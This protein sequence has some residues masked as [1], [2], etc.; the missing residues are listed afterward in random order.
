[1]NKF[2]RLEMGI[3][4]FL[5]LYLMFTSIN[6]NPTLGQ[7]YLGFITLSLIYV[8]VDPSRSIPFKKSSDSTLGAIVK[9]AGAY[10][11]LIVVGSYIIVPGINA[12]RRLL[13]STTPALATNPVLNSFNFG[14]VIPYV[15]TFF[16]F[17]VSLDFLAS[18]FGVKISKKNL[19][20][21][22]LW[23]IMMG[24]ALAFML[25]HLTA[26]SVG[27]YDTLALVFF[28]AIISLVLVVWDESYQS[29][30]AFH[31]IANCAALFL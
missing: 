31:V 30:V 2:T 13:S 25:F 4:F 17:A 24:L 21:L 6:V 7:I 16:F 22:S 20:S 27:A 18:I 9:G 1:M 19:K 3:L 5:G 28:M 26:K 23:L 15:E 29:A 10:V 8:M 12:V 11:V 14:G